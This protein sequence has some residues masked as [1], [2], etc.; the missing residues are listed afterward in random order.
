[1]DQVAQCVIPS[2][3]KD[4][5]EFQFIEKD[6]RDRNEDILAQATFHFPAKSVGG[7]DEE[8]TVAEEFQKR[9]MGTGVIKSITGKIIAEF[10][11]EQGNFVTPRGKYGLQV[12]MW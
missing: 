5:I 10:S 6:S 9:I 2:N 11:K 3:S 1:M 8:Q 12:K 7:E 4:E